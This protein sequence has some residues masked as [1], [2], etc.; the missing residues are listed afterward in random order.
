MSSMNGSPAT[1]ALSDLPLAEF[2]ERLAAR[3]PAPGG[4]AGAAVCGALAAGLVQMVSGYEEGGPVAGAAAD[5]RV[6]AAELR[7][8]LLEEAERDRFA[9]EPVLVALRRPAQD[10]ERPAE[11][12]AALSAAADPPLQMARDAA[13]LA[14]LAAAAAD[15]AGRHL[16]GDCVVAAVLA[17]AACR[18]ATVLVALNLEGAAADRRREEA[19]RL[20]VTAE[21]AGRNA[22]LKANES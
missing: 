8:A 15:R 10:P 1:G 19:E 9:Y 12:A 22:L 6:R 16:I 20:A 7:A 17:S 3:T 11:L 2:L 13:E 5:R 4:G 14:E 18:A 21:H